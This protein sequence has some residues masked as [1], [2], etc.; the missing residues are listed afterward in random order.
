[1]SSP[2]QYPQLPPGVAPL[3]AGIASEFAA[4]R[5]GVEEAVRHL[6]PV[7]TFPPF[8]VQD[9]NFV[10]PETNTAG[11]TIANGWA[12][13]GSGYAVAAFEQLGT[14]V[15]LRGMLS[16]VAGALSAGTFYAMATLP[17]GVRPTAREPFSGQA[18]SPVVTA[19]V[20][21][22]ADGTITY[23]GAAI[24]VNGYVSLSGINFS[25]L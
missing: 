25:T 19:R 21:V 6:P 11:I 8:P 3:V 23:Y 22:L 1:M 4:I 5:H 2:D 14:R 20:D 7:I 12:N 16:N 10:R 17:S 18:G 13:F 24:G 15:F 9:T